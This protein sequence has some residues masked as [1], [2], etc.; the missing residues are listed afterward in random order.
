MPSKHQ[1]KYFQKDQKHLFNKVGQSVFD[2]TFN[3][4]K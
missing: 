2:D 3:T 4:R 1:L